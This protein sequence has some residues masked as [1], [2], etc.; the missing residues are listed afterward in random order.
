MVRNQALFC[1]A[2]H[3]KVECWYQLTMTQYHFKKSMI[4]EQ[5]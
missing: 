2:I 5:L 4:M 1:L 3:D